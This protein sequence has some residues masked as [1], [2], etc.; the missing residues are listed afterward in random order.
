MAVVW[1]KI[2]YSED[3]ILETF[4]AAKG[5]LISASAASTPLILSVGPDTQVLTADSLEA[6]GLKW[7]A[8]AGT[9]DVTA[10]ANMTD[11]AIVKGDGGAKGVQDSGILIDD[12]EN[13]SAINDITFG[14]T[15]YVFDA[16]GETIVGDGTDLTLTAGGAI[17]LTATTDVVVP[18]NVGITFGT[19][20]K[21]EGDDTD[22][23]LT[24]GA[25]I[26]LAA[27]A[28]VN[29]PVSVG[30][31]LGDGAEKIESDN[32]DLTINSGVDINLTAT[33]DINVPANVGITF[34]DDGEKIEGDGT[35]LTIESSGTLSLNST[36]AI[37][38]SH[39]GIADNNVVTVDGTPATTELALW[40]A[41]GLDGATPAAVAATMA[42]DDIGVPDAAVDFDLQQ[43]TDLVVMTVANEAALPAA[44]IAVGQLC[45]CTGELT[46]HICTSAA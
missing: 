6:T 12:S 35:N 34:G 8:V 2:A 20:E 13:I 3:V 1:K 23:T 43:A 44:N 32:T 38:A 16:G 30:V 40:T 27:T 4:M 24:S 26:T 31:V 36:G 25:D 33:T 18:V 5:D 39:Q 11:N 19:G 21:I 42:L 7:A 45:F 15:M 14:G 41:A 10:A 22:L 17:E 37:T 28:D 9:G 46:L 29:I